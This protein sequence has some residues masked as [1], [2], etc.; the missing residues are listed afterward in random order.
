MCGGGLELHDGG[1][2]P[3]VSQSRGDVAVGDVGSGHGDVRCLQPEWFCD[4]L[5][6]K[7]M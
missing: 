4:E 5:E 1:H 2:R 7:C 6:S 3:G